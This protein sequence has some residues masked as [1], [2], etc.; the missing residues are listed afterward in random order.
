MGSY[1]RITPRIKQTYDRVR[2]VGVDGAAEELN[3]SRETVRRNV[4]AYKSLTNEETG[5]KPNEKILRQLSEKFSERELK[6]ILSSS[7]IQ[8]NTTSIE[9]YSF[10]GDEITIGCLTDTHLGSIYTNVDYISA[11]FDEFSRQGVDIVTHSGDVHEGLSH[12]PGHVYECS[13]VGYSQ[14][15]EHS[16]EVFG[17]WTDTPIYM[18][19][20]N[21]DR[22][23][24]KSTGALIVKELCA[25]QENL[26][27]LGHDEGDIDING[28][29]VRL[30]HGEDAGSY[31]LSYRLQKLIEAFSGGEKPN[32]LITGHT[33]KALYIF[34]RNVHCVS[35]GTI[36]KQSSWMRSKRLAAHVGFW[37]I[38]MTINDGEVRSFTPTFYPFYS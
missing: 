15:L 31:A 3:I 27:Y 10:D 36:Q 25:G 7:Q 35:A 34:E 30:W 2:E 22:W 38:K 20:G 29:V 6:Q 32:V 24:I 8:N 23:Y 9:K 12:R 28:V 17:Q 19:D 18:I 26:Y 4:R 5:T 21:H 1:K 14:Q 11:A 33:H 37:I 13:H 16:R